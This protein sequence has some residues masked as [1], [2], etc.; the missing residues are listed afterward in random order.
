M[1]Y[2]FQSIPI[3]NYHLHCL[4]SLLRPSTNSRIKQP[5]RSQSVFEV[6]FI[7][8]CHVKFKT[9]MEVL[10][11]RGTW[12]WLPF[13]YPRRWKTFGSDFWPPAPAIDSNLF[14]ALNG[15]GA[16]VA[17]VKCKRGCLAFQSVVNI[18]LDIDR[19]AMLQNCTS[20]SGVSER[21]HAYYSPWMNLFRRFRTH[22]PIKI[23]TLSRDS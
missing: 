23:L 9:G 13:P 8:A 5:N 10:V 2:K 17:I 15:L 21:I 1:K 14:A 12:R 16:T 19:H 7:V 4:S 22:L 20:S 11:E 6:N 3:P 18:T